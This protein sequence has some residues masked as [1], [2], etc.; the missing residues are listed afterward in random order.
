M[1]VDSASPR[2]MRWWRPT[3]PAL[4]LIGS[5]CVNIVLVSYIAT[6]ALTAKPPMSRP[7]PEEM[8]ATLAARLPSTD[9]ELL[10]Q[11]YRRLEPKVLAA[12]AASQRA[13]VRALSLLSQSDLDPNAL[14]AAFR[15]A[16]DNR[17]RMGELLLET[18]VEGLTRLSPEARRKLVQKHHYR[19]H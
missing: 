3:Y 10:W 2:P 7:A 15:E 12:D 4:A 8:V 19:F 18:V 14:Q 9:A 1:T 6:Q 11:A 17:I 16:L 5:I 13:R